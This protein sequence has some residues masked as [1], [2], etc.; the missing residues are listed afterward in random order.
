MAMDPT[1]GFI[2]N[3]LHFTSLVFLA[4]FLPLVL[5]FE[6]KPTSCLLGKHFT[7]ESLPA[8]TP[9]PSL[10]YFYNPVLESGLYQHL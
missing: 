9:T 6:P 7:M 1:E 8:P 4:G 2:Q 3:Q 5:G 10:V